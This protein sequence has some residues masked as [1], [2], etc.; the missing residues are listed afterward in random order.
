[1]EHKITFAGE[2]RFCLNHSTLHI[3]KIELYSCIK[4]AHHTNTDMQYK[5]WSVITFTSTFFQYGAYLYKQNE[6]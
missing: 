1:M 4:T 2:F 6:R 5:V 3:H